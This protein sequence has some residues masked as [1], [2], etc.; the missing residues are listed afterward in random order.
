MR[1]ATNQ[2]GHAVE[3]F[4]GLRVGWIAITEPLTL[5]EA[6]TKLDTMARTPGAEYRIYPALKR[7]KGE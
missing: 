6:V 1:T 3:R 7:D 4:D 5:A 2:I